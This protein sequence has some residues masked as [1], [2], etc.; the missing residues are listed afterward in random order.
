M[1][2][3]N[4]KS[5]KISGL[6]INYYYICHRKLWFFDK[7]ITAENTSERVKIG[8]LLTNQSYQSYKKR[9]I[10]IDETINLDIVSKEEVIEIKLSNRLEEAQKMQLLYYLYYL[11]K[12]GTNKK[13]ILVYPKLKKREEVELKPEDEKELENALVRIDEITK[14]KSPPPLERKPFCTKCSYYELCFS[15]EVWNG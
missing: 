5:L 10:L 7:G 2:E 1:E 9:E 13:G 6:K 14:L 3:I 11:K 15:G 4:F 8:R 12:L